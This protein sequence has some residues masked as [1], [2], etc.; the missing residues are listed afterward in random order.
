[1]FALSDL[2]THGLQVLLRGSPNSMLIDIACL[3]STGAVIA[4]L[5]AVCGIT[6]KL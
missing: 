6:A 4:E 3:D 2:L 1:M 5:P